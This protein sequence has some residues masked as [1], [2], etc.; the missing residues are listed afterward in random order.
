MYTDWF[1]LRQLPFRLRPDP[2]FLYLGDAF[3][4]PA[5]WLREYIEGDTDSILLLGGP[6]S[7]KSTLLRA[8]ATSGGQRRVIALLQP[9]LG[10]AELVDALREQ[11]GPAPAGGAGEDAAVELERRFAGASA[12][13]RQVL[14]V[15]DGA[16]AL[17]MATLSELQRLSL[18]RASPRW[19]IAAEPSGVEVLARAAPRLLKTMCQVELAPLD[20]A[21]TQAYIEHRLR[22]AGGGPGALFEHAA[23][24]EIRRCTDGN[25][26]RINRLCDA[27]MLQASARSLRSV[28]LAEVRAAV[29]EL[30]LAPPPRAP[31][32][33]ATLQVTCG[34]APA[35]GVSLQPGRLVI[36]RASDSGLQLE[37]EFVSRRHCHVLT[38]SAGSVI[39][40]LDSTN[41][42]LANGRARRR[43][44]LQPGDSIVIGRYTLTYCEPGA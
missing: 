35:V 16:H 22:V 8:L 23:V 5:E 15:I 41:G 10:P 11:L 32:A 30:N 19:L 40:D 31:A 39:E 33:R 37:G 7:G 42:F 27:A 36:G 4:R 6:G 26:A 1:Q 43:H 2:P 9:Q 34:S 21:G 12:G 29:H 13:G 20:R 25:P 24:D 3:E 18:L 14:V 38:T 44:R 17:P 28:S